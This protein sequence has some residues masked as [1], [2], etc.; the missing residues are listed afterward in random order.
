MP[1]KQRTALGLIAGGKHFYAF[2]FSVWSEPLIMFHV[3]S[4]LLTV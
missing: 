4:T 1:E 3:V 2:P